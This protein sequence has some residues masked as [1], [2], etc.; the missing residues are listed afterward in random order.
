[1]SAC[2]CSSVTE[3]SKSIISVQCLLTMTNIIEDYHFRTTRENGA[4]Q[5]SVVRAR[6]CIA[7]RTFHPRERCPRPQVSASAATA[8]SKQE[9]PEW[10]VSSYRAQHPSILARD[11]WGSHLYILDYHTHS[12]RI[13]K[14]LR[15]GKA[16][17]QVSEEECYHLCGDQDDQSPRCNMEECTAKYALVKEKY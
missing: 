1:M 6:C 9:V 8:A 11:T 7:E 17:K 2:C 13:N 10:G 12:R 15:Y 3:V 5:I 4:I 16:F 14:R